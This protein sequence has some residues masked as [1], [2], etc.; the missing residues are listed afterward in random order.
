VKRKE[1][2]KEKEK[3]GY[4]KEKRQERGQEGSGGNRARLTLA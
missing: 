2:G 3:G 1:K 4:L